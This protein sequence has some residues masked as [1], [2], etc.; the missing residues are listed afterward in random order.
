MNDVYKHIKEV[1]LKGFK[2]EC[3]KCRK[4]IKS[5]YKGHLE[6]LI[7]QHMLGVHKGEK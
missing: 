1:T 7:D 5:L 6:A 2:W 4:A 3:P